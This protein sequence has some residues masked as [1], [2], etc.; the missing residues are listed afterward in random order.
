MN[1][2]TPNSQ[3]TFVEQL[4]DPTDSGTNYV[5]C[6]IR[7]SS[8]SKT[9]ATVN[10]TDHGG[11]RFTALFTVP[12][13]LTGQGYY[14]DVTTTVYSDSGYTQPNVDYQIQTVSY[15]VIQPVTNSNQGGGGMDEQSFINLLKKY[16]RFPKIKIPEQKDIDLSPLH[17]RLDQIEKRRPRDVDLSPVIG[18]L[19]DLHTK[20]SSI[21][22]PEL[23]KIDLGP[24]ISALQQISRNHESFRTDMTRRSFAHEQAIKSMLQDTF[25]SISGDVSK[26]MTTAVNERMSDLLHLEISPPKAS[27][28]SKGP[29]LDPKLKKLISPYAK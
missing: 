24:I 1:Q 23:E 17:A 7:Y 8:T 14:L 4:G 19:A 25:S 13:D 28:K 5:R 20:V 27:S 11:Q 2:L 16:I 3:F 6:I 15:F 26:S 21:R 12:A 9:V 29:Q 22:I 18:S 10:M